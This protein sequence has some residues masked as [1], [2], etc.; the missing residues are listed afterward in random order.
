MTNPKPSPA[1]IKVVRAEIKKQAALGKKAIK[2][3][4]ARGYAAALAE[5]RV[6]NQWL[7]AYVTGDNAAK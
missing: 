1:Q 4:D 5:V 3:G 7:V 6:L 2:R